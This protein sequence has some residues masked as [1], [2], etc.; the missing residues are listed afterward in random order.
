MLLW[1][2]SKFETF[3]N[4]RGFPEKFFL[5]RAGISGRRSGLTYDENYQSVLA[6]N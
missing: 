4:K 3:I 2:N 5:V 1:A 6:K